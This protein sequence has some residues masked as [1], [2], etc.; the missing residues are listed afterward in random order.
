MKSQM[1]SSRETVYA[2]VSPTLTV[3][4]Y[5][6]RKDA[7]RAKQR[8]DVVRAMRVWEEQEPTDD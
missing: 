8:G 4:L 5:A 7:R 1:W 3:T 2:T 6:K